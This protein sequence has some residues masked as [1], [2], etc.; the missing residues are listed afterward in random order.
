MTNWS[1][2][3]HPGRKP[4]K[5]PAPTRSEISEAIQEYLNRGGKITRIEI[6]PEMPEEIGIDQGAVHD[7]LTAF[8]YGRVIQCL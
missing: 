2:K 6:L 4:K 1:T 7:Y 3:D 5:Q 8:E